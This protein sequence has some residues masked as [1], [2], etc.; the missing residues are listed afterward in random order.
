MNFWM[1]EISFLSSSVFPFLFSNSTEF[2]IIACAALGLFLRLTIDLHPFSFVFYIFFFILLLHIHSFLTLAING[3]RCRSKCRVFWERDFL[4][5][6]CSL[7][8][9]MKM[10]EEKEKVNLVS[11]TFDFLWNGKIVEILHTDNFVLQI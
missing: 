6:C 4:L 5:N 1:G 3:N 8:E 7:R 2:N 9:M 10:W 11:T